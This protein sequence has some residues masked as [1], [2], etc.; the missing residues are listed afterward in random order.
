M[1]R[2]S[3]S[4]QPEGELGD[5]DRVL[6]RAV[7]DV[8][9]AL[10]RGLD[11][12]RVVARARADDQRRAGRPRASGR[13]TFVERTTSTSAPRRRRA[14]LSARRPSRRARRATSHPTAAQ[15]LR[16]RD[17]SN[18]SATRT[19]IEKEILDLVNQEPV[20]EL[21]LEPRR[22][23]RHDPAGVGDPPSGRR[24]RRDRARS[25]RGLTPSR[26][27]P[28]ALGAA[29]AADE[30]DALVGADVLDAE[31]RLQHLLLEE[32]DVQR[33]T[34]GAGRA[35]AGGSRTSVRRRRWRP[36]PGARVTEARFGETG[37][38]A[39]R[40]REELRGRPPCRGPSPR[41]CTEGSGAGPAGKATARKK[42]Y[43]S[44]PVSPGLPRAPAGRGRRSPRGG[45]RR[46]CRGGARGR[47]PRRGAVR[48]R[49]R[50]P[51]S[52]RDPVCRG[53]VVEG[54]LAR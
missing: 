9:A 20:P 40:A 35:R 25:D 3:A 32:A 1:R 7:G 33:R 48:R 13:V 39:S 38:F 34:V 27:R 44:A 14:V 50:A 15:A 12:D 46:R 28:R 49:D 43:G 21:R 23:R 10:G 42:S 53:E 51:E 6:A 31:K 8:D 2:S 41:G 52:V 22:L 47:K 26:R 19:F 54:R 18:L 45:G 16:G 17:S 37:S 24:A 11:V 30:V 4:D 29:D 36:R 5:G